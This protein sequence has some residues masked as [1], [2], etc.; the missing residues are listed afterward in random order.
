VFALWTGILAGPAIWLMLLE[1]NY[2][3]SYVAC[4]TGQTWFL[5]L[6]TVVAVALVAAAGL[7]AWRAVHRP[8]DWSEPLTAPVGPE[9]CD[10]RARWMS[11][12]AVT[13][14]AWFIVVIIATEVPAI[15]LSP[16]Q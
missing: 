8:H 15:V 7:W 10:V 11:R 1:A 3:L 5:H 13:S 12:L 14:C 4:E 16:C 6:N 9:T 2:V